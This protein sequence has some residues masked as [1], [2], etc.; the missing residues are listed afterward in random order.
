M[1][2]CVEGLREVDGQRHH[3]AGVFPLVKAQCYGVSNRKEG[4][5]GGL[6]GPE[7]MLCRH[8][9]EVLT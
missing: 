3:V 1:G 8:S 2:D 6:L 4:S 5:G 7:T 9:V